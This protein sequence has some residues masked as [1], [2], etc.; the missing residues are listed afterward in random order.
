MAKRE[1]LVVI[2]GHALIHRAYHAIPPLTTK[3]GEVV[4]AVY[5]FSMILLNVLRELKP[6]Y[7]AVAFDLPGKTKR[8]EAYEQYKAHRKAAPDDL[9]DQ[10]A[11][12]RE[13]IEAFS[14]PIYSKEGYEA[15]D[16]IGTITKKAPNDIESIIVTG[17]M[18][19]L[20]L[21]DE[22]TKV[23]TMR[24]GFTD[25]IIYDEAAVKEKYGLTPAQFVDY[26]ALRGDPSDNIP[27]VAGVGEKTATDLIKSYGSL[28]NVYKNLDDIKPAVAKKLAEDKENAFL[29]RKL[30]QLKLNLPI[31]IDLAKCIVHDFDKARVFSLFQ[32]L[33]FKSLLSRLP[34]REAQA[35]IF[36]EPQKITKDGT[37][38][39]IHHAKYHL[40]T[41]EKELDTLAKKLKQTKSFAFDTET[42]SLNEIN[43][44]LVGMSFSFT[45]G[46]AY[47]I[48]VGHKE[49]TQLNKERVLRSLRPVLEDK[50]IGKVGH[51]IKYDYIVLKK[52]GVTISPVTFDTMVG[53]YLI[54]PVARA[55]KLDE[56]AFAELGL[57]MVKISEL[58][59]SGKDEITFDAVDIEKAKIYACEDA[60]V[61][62]RLYEHLAAD[63]K[64]SDLL[65]LMADIEAPLI[66]IL[67][68]MELAGI[69]VDTKKLAKIS[70]D[71]AKRIKA[72]ETDIYKKAGTKFNIASP[73]Q[74]GEV[75]F[76]KL[77]LDEKIEDKRELKKLKSGGYSTSASE[78]EKLRGV[79]PIIDMISEFRELSK[80][81]NTYV[82]VL[83]TL[84]NAQTGRVH[85]SFN[86][87]I[88]QTGR[89]SSSDPN[90][91]NIPIRTEEGKK[92]REAFV[93]DKDN[94]LLSADYSQI[95]LRVIAHIASDK[96]MIEIF[97]EDR[98]IHTETAAKVY[99]FP[100]NKVTPA[101]RRIAKIVNFGIIY[102]VSAHG[103]KQQTGMTREE[104]QNFIDKYFE[105]HPK[106]KK[107]TG[108]VV[109]QAKE[110]G[111]VETLFG[112]RRYLPE[113]KSNNFAVRGAAER[114]AI[115][116][117]IQGTA[118]DLMKLAM[119]DIAKL[120]PSVSQN[121][122]ML[123]QVHD[124]L[125]F[126]VPEKDAKKVAEFVKD[127]MENVVKLSV[128]IEV[129]VGWGSNWGSAKD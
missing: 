84:V 39:H 101:M 32:E 58:I 33:G 37:R 25:T 102:G 110:L 7:I 122:K 34:Q 72:L 60:D 115:N 118:A 79:H 98:D 120:L 69:S 50:G 54:N 103:L 88:T 49:G 19:E 105:L 21:V 80:L 94:V 73:A 68:E 92:I 4:N 119:I 112:R 29:S 27:G 55:L 30:S 125:V 6:K 44:N 85:T 95:E 14:I 59:G 52:Y 114:M 3:K 46:E 77:K 107:Y 40:I 28:E 99:G 97:K 36:E 67:G 75:L 57:E 108:D 124:E 121:S 35:S 111:Y 56:L 83:P 18:D 116:M 93:S 126:E 96:D 106:V 24:R 128:P 2:D 53:A 100:Q 1:K 11:R 63:L 109:K 16:V 70:A 26:K 61:T 123:L 89:L 5:G 90:L 41:T 76:T 43:A 42:D 12:V 87:A 48:P 65:E 81:K 64:K 45:K 62:W 51:N 74:L 15:D 17:D 104:G 91:Q 10:I 23:Y 82:D 113:I 8:H 129:S 38:K 86:Q 71:F 31:K 66:P 78:L 47:Y 22:K 20:Q 127:K 13:V 117:P 9:I